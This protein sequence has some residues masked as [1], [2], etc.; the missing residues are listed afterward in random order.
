MHPA[1]W[2]HGMQAP[3]TG[4]SKQITHEEEA[5]SPFFA[6]SVGGVLSA[7]GFDRSI[8][9]ESI[10]G[11]WIGYSSRLASKTGGADGIGADWVEVDRIAADWV[12]ADRIESE[13]GVVWVGESWI[14]GSPVE[15]PTGPV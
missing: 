1:I 9:L 4:A 8:G 10:D 11:Y 12:E 15:P 14:S 2:P 6:S 13:V 7:A 5:P 3:S